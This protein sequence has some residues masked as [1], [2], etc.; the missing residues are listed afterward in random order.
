MKKYRDPSFDAFR[1]L[2]IIAVVAIHAIDTDFPLRYGQSN[3]WGTFLYRQLI[4]FAVPTFIFISGYWMAKK[5]ITSLQDYK[6]FLV[7]RLSRVFVPYLFWSLISIGSVILVVNTYDINVY[8]IIFK[9]L[10]GGSVRGYFFIILISQLYIITPLLQYMNNKSYGLMFVLIFNMLSLL[11]LYLS[12]VLNVIGHVPAALPFY[13]WIVFYEIGLLIG[14]RN[15]K[16]FVRK[17]IGLLIFPT[18]FIFLLI[19]A[20]EGSIL[21]S[22]YNNLNFGRSALKY[23][24]FL[25]SAFVVFGFLFLRANFNRWPKFL[26]TIGNYSFGVYL[27]HTFILD[28]IFRLVEKVNVI[29][30]FTFLR[31]LVIVS[32]T[33]AICVILI[34]ITRKL[35]PTSFCHRLL[36]FQ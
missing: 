12:R 34:G 36:G 4:N 10:T 19:S 29:Y 15:N 30:T 14:G 6:T 24:S 27:I 17:N 23:S 9:L 13:S 28:K 7:T 33:I 11:A 16:I 22:Q 26:V 18:V 8:Q 21:I 31:Q 5:P 32:I 1:G 20:L 25:Y 35:L 2:A 3:Q